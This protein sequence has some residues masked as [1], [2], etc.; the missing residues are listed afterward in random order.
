MQESAIYPEIKAE[1]K[2]EGIAEG[3]QQAVQRERALVLRL[4]GLKIGIL[5]EAEQ[6]QISQLSLDQLEVLIAR[7]PEFS[8][9]ESLANWLQSDR[10]TA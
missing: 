4:L 6:K 8:T 3:F 7:L 1:G 9:V 5:P 2:A 10:P